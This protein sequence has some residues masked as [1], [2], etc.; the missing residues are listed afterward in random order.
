[1]LEI[2]FA[3][4]NK[5]K[6]REVR[7]LALAFKI[8]IIGI[9]DLAEAIKVPV[10]EETGTTYLENCRIKAIAYQK[11]FQRTVLVDDSGIEVEALD[12]APGV[13]SADYAGKAAKS[14]ANIRKLWGELEKLHLDK[15]NV[16]ARMCCCAIIWDG[17]VE[18]QAYGVIEGRIIFEKRGLGGF[19]FDSIFVPE[20]SQES[21]S[22]L[23]D[24]G[25]FVDTHRGK[26]MKEI[27][28]FM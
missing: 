22:E 18:K 3:T 8:K 7:D 9:N 10:V 26:A 27:F 20:Q 19:G 13:Y 4:S 6:F 14:E 23:K 16:K 28:S 11:I 25:L 17:A 15:K 12:G 2:L 24:K 1:M 5:G 21:I